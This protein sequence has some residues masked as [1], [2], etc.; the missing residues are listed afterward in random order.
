MIN[1]G[2][3]LFSFCFVGT[4]WLIYALNFFYQNCKTCYPDIKILIISA[5]HDLQNLCKA[6]VH[7][8]NR[9][10]DVCD[11]EWCV[12]FDSLRYVILSA[13]TVNSNG[14]LH[15]WTLWLRPEGSGQNLRQ[16]EGREFLWTKGRG[17]TGDPHQ[18]GRCCSRKGHWQGR[19]DC[20]QAEPLRF[21]NSLTSL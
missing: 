18:D 19:Q 13:H 6:R 11:L 4:K 12:D 17:E 1:S 14:F 5:S 2:S 9:F 16:T 3:L 7:G 21:R 20:K 15:C 8:D 10:A